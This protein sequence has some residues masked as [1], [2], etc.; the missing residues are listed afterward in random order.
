M[1]SIK[2]LLVVALATLATVGCATKPTIQLLSSDEASAYKQRLDQIKKV[3]IFYSN[4]NGIVVTDGGG[5]GA[6]GLGGLLGPVGAI[7]AAAADAASKISSTERA[8]VR[9]KEYSDK[10]RKDLPDANL[11]RAF[12]EALADKVRKTGREVKLT[13][14]TS[15]RTASDLST[16][17]ELSSV[18]EDVAAILIWNNPGF[19]AESSTSAYQSSAVIDFF[20]QDS[21][22]VKLLDGQI[23]NA[24]DTSI[25]SFSGL[26]E[27]IGESFAKLSTNYMLGHERIVKACLDVPTEKKPTDTLVNIY[28]GIQK[29]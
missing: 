7:L 3:E 25:R 26:L 21:K 5:S 10:V 24:T 8:K 19:S 1:I 6:V 14:L 15:N 13:A 17:K 22:R 4:D 18:E 16:Y 27:N 11:S 23:R 12:A 29:Q 2:N 20:C 9:G 28:K